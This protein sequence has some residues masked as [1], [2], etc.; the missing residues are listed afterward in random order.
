MKF[1]AKSMLVLLL[2]AVALG[3][4]AYNLMSSNVKQSGTISL[5][6]QNLATETRRVG[7]DIEQVEM[8]GPFDLA[9]EQSEH[10]SLKIEGEE[11]LLP[12]VVLQQEGKILR[13]TTTGML[14]TLNQTVKLTLFIPKLTSLTQSGS[15][16]SEVQGFTGSDINLNLN[17]SGS[18]MFAGTYRH[19]LVQTKGSG[20]VELNVPG[21][22]Q[23]EINSFGS[24]EVVVVGKAS[25]LNVVSTGSGDIDAER[26]IAQKSDVISHGTGGIKVYADKEVSGKRRIT[27]SAGYSRAG[28]TRNVHVDVFCTKSSHFFWGLAGVEK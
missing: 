13:I 2:I 11:R 21:A 5:A 26:L 8:N 16:D 4:V 23:V 1:I 14:V 3:V 12:K 20:D 6:P 17:G 24:G 18:V 15:G 22:D 19:L 28:M 9:I 10:A 27:W 7:D 25:L